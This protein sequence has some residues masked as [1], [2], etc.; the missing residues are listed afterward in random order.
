MRGMRPR[1]ALAAAL[2]VLLAAPAPALAVEPIPAA[3]GWRGFVVLGAG[4]VDVRSNLVVG[5]SMI[6]VGQPVIDS[7]NQRPPSDDAFFPLLTGEINYTTSSGWQAFLGN[8]LEDLVTLDS[9]TQL[10]VRS[11]VGNAGTV[12]AGLLLG[13]I[14]TKAWADPYAEGVRREETDRDANGVRLQWGR[15]MGSALQ[16]G[17]TYLDLSFDAER[18]GQGVVS[19]GC[20]AA[21][22][23]ALRR[24]GSQYA[25]DVSH[26]YRL[27]AAR[28][29]LLRPMFRYTVDDRDG[30]AVA[31]DSYRFQLSYVYVTQAYSVASNIVLGNTS[32]DERNPLFGRRTNSDRFAIDTTLFYRLPAPSSRWQA[33]GSILWGEDDSDVDFHDN[34]VFMVSLGAMYRFGGR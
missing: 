1:F 30:G 22:Q 9:V 17:V 25:L 7:I 14:Q 33:V 32:R 12:E 13:G 24:D 27:G 16:L 20:D 21:C 31:S 34:R 11:N 19:V 26:L 6:D 4:S 5:N 15:V 28:N 29:H 10:G 18:S 8:S 2:A 23:S 3:P